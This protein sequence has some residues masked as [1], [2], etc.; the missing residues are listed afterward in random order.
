[1]RAPARVDGAEVTP[2]RVARELRDLAGHLDAG[3]PGSDDDE[4]EPGGAPSGIGLC[5]RGLEGAQQL[6]AHDERALERFHLGGVLAPLLVPEVRVARAAG[7]DQR[8]VAQPLRRRHAG[9]RAQVQ[10]APLE[11][12]VGDLG[13]DDAGR[14]GCA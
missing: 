12:E 7:D 9:D 11:V 3:R 13:Q 14:C 5:L 2:S 8:V 1:M 4:G 6:G 10:L